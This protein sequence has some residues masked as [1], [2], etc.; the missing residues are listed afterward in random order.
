MKGKVYYFSICR[1]T[2]SRIFTQ[3][4]L[5]INLYQ[6]ILK[7]IIHKDF[8]LN[9]N[10]IK[11]TKNASPSTLAL[12]LQLQHGFILKWRVEV[13]GSAIRSTLAL[14]I[15]FQ[16]SSFSTLVL[17]LQIQHSSFSTLA[18]ALQLQHGFILKWRVE[19]RGSAIR[20]TLALAIQF[21]HSRFSTLVLALQIQHSSFSTVSY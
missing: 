14:A 2:S 6:I 16:D 20:S 11:K 4:Q 17:A 1:M 5:R 19:V 18:L 12:A 7:P 15:Q 13:R 3:T 8:C 9:M 21:Q 10:E